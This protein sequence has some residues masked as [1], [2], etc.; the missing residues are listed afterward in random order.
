LS[1]LTAVTVTPTCSLPHTNMLPSCGRVTSDK[2]KAAI[3]LRTPDFYGVREIFL[4]FLSS[5]E[6]DPD[7]EPARVAQ[8]TPAVLSELWW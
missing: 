5:A 2:S 1:G 8:C 6:T 4:A 3:N 7:P